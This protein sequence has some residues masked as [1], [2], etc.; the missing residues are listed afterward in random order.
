VLQESSDALDVFLLVFLRNRNIRTSWFEF[1]GDQLAEAVLNRGERLIN[2][3]RNVVLPEGTT[4]SAGQ[5]QDSKDDL[6]NPGH[7][8]V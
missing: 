2:D 5:R 6:Q 4:K 8:T 3:V 7:S 1:D